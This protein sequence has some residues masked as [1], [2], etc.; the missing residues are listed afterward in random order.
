[1]GEFVNS[2]NGE[3]TVNFYCNAK[4]PGNYDVTLVY[5][6]GSEANHI[7]WTEQNQKVKAGNIVAGNKDSNVTK[8]IQFTME[9]LEVGPRVITFSTDEKNAPQ[10]DHFIITNN[11]DPL[12]LEALAN[13][14]ADAEALD[15]DLYEDG[16]A[17]GVFKV[18]LNEAQA[19]ALDLMKDGAAKD[20][21]KEALKAAIAVL[22][23]EN[24]N[25]AMVQE[26][27]TKLIQA[28]EALERKPN[29]EW[30]PPTGEPTPG[31]NVDGDK[32]KTVPNTG[33]MTQM[34]AYISLLL[35]SMM[36]LATFKKEAE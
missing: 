13:A 7:S 36:G 19:I 4:Q 12:Q 15:L 16:Q 5:H 8:E 1:M 31:P 22:E 23:D 6:S 20:N 25:E 29:P 26:A 2:M 34:F 27:K 11:Q 24:A 30:T 35:V 3:D 32:D 28:M 18:A 17:K 10:M 9:V 33:D 14:I 21:F